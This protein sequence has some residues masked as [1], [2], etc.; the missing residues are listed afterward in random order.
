MVAE[1]END[2]IMLESLFASTFLDEVEEF[3]IIGM[4]P[5]TNFQSLPIGSPQRSR[6][7]SEQN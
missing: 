2:I 1:H 4:E 6:F 7:V 5:N 3:G